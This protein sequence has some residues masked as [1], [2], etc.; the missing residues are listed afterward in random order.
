MIAAA[1]DTVDL[2]FRYT[3]IETK[4]LT[5]IKRHT[6]Q[7]IYISGSQCHP[8]KV[9]DLPIKQFSGPSTLCMIKIILI[10]QR[11]VLIATLSCTR[12]RKDEAILMRRDCH[13][14]LRGRGSCTVVGLSIK[15]TFYD[16][17][18]MSD[19]PSANE[20]SSN[21]S[22]LKLDLSAMPA[23]YVYHIRE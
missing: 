6:L 10:T 23:S 3:H 8:H 4:A 2:Y 11:V 1:H 13:L 17:R 18:K 9:N 5:H 16:S 12:I 7:Y 21:L 19:H 14:I 20:H 15:M 22:G